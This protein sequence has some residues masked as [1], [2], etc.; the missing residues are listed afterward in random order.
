[1]V[2]VWARVVRPPGLESPACTLRDS[3]NYIGRQYHAR[4][5]KQSFCGADGR[6]MIEVRQTNPDHRVSVCRKTIK[7]SSLMESENPFA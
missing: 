1:M 5:V 3:G 2:V 7:V 6:D 4:T